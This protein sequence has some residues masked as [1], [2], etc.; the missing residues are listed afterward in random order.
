MNGILH[1]AISD[2]FGFLKFEI[3]K[4]IICFCMSYCYNWVNAGLVLVIQFCVFSVQCPTFSD[5]CPTILF[6]FVI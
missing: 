2:A 1:C 5:H 4:R 6:E 3:S